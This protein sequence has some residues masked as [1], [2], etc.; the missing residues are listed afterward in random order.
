MAP[1][2]QARV[3]AVGRR[4]KTECK[5]VKLVL[6]FSVASGE[7]DLVCAIIGIGILMVLMLCLEGIQRR[8]LFGS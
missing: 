3:L 5:L 7:T 8:T 2:F 6:H 1:I 4:F